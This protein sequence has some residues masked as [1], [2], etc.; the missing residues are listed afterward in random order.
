[1]TLRRTFSGYRLRRS[2][3]QDAAVSAI[4]AVEAAVDLLAAVTG[5]GGR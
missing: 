4:T 2:D 1:M 5:G 3:G